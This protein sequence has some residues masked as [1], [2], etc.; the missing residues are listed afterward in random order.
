MQER[1]RE[2]NIPIELLR[3]LVAITETRSFT[4]AA[5]KMFLSQPA[6]SA[7][8]R[9]LHSIVGGPLFQKGVGGV[10]LNA[11]GQL[12]IGLVRRLL[13]ANDRIL[14]LANS[15]SHRERAIRV[16]VAGVYAREVMRILAQ[17]PDRRSIHIYS[18]HSDQIAKGVSEA[19]IDVGCGMF[20][21]SPSRNAIASWEEP[22]VWVRSPDF[23]LSPGAVIPLVSWPDIPADRLA[24]QALERIGSRYE[25]VFASY[26][27]DDRIAAVASGA[28]VMAVAER[29]VKPPLVIGRDYYLPALGVMEAGIY[30]RDGV[31]L[32]GFPGLAE[33]LAGV[34]PSVSVRRKH[35]EEASEPDITP[36]AAMRSAGRR[37][38]DSAA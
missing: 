35:F 10:A 8:V 6:I 1:Y 19:Y 15:S 34:A 36:V 5:A 2:N 21:G 18:D 9:R 37:R 20:A 33:S 7:Q 3:T 16:G 25:V 24:I 14:S 29:V 11:R 13:D 17:R 28:G 12:V 38:A 30:V 32:E 4:K 23:L 27:H 31:D 26:D 22:L